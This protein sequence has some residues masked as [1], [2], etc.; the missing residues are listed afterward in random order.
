MS[1]LFVDVTKINTSFNIISARYSEYL[2]KKNELERGKFLYQ[3][4]LNANVF[5]DFS[6][7]NHFRF[8]N[9]LLEKSV[10]FSK[11]YGAS[12]R[13]PLH[14]I[15]RSLLK[16]IDI[17]R[18]SKTFQ[19]QTNA[20]FFVMMMICWGF[21]F[22]SA[23]LMGTKL[24]SS[25]LVALFL[26]QMIGFISFN[27]VFRLRNER[28]TSKYSLLFKNFITYQTLLEVSL[29]ISEVKRLCHFSDLVSVEDKGL[30]FFI[31]R[32]FS[33]IKIREEQGRE[34]AEDISFLLDD[35]RL[36]YEEA[37]DGNLKFLTVLKF[38]W[39]VVFFLST[40]LVSVYLTISMVVS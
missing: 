38:I 28:M 2:L 12:F 16:E 3:F 36:F 26:W 23:N 34:T 27:H 13:K 9:D 14:V 39:L 18:K 19:G 1:V 10:L 17:V 4:L 24:N 6:K 8:Y 40:Y 31:D 11:N 37:L 32:F 15:K 29:P 33:L 5:T 25:M 20:Q 22:Y 7:L 35:F 30:K 21:S